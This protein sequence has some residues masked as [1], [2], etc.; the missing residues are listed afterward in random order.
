MYLLRNKCLDWMVHQGS[1]KEKAGPQK[2]IKTKLSSNADPSKSARL[3]TEVGW[4]REKMEK[5][6]QSIQGLTYD[7]K[8]LFAYVHEPRPLHV[9]RTLDQ[10]YYYTLPD[11]DIRKRDLDQ[12]LFRHTNRFMDMKEKSRVLMVDQLWM[13]IIEEPNRTSESRWRCQFMIL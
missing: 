5:Y 8:A 10:S 2:D 12:V 11:G 6:S 13:W 7:A 4:D 3:D 9:R 1:P